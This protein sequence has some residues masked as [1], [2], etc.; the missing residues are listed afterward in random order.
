MKFCIMMRSW[1]DEIMLT[2]LDA[3]GSVNDF[4][5]IITYIFI[6]FKKHTLGPFGWSEG[7]VGVV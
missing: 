7:V 6:I 3:N 1:N 4:I 5:I 2:S